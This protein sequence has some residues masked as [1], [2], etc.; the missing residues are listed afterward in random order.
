M[1]RFFGHSKAQWGSYVYWKSNAIQLLEKESI[2]IKKKGGL[3]LIGSVTDCYQPIEKKLHLTR[4]SLRIFL[5]NQIPI[6]ILTKSTLAERDFDLLTQFNYCEF[7]VSVSIL[8]SKVSRTFEPLVSTPRERIK[9]LRKANQSGLDTYTFIGPIHPFLSNTQAIFRRVSNIT[10]SIMGEIINLKCGNWKNIQSSL[11]K[12]DIFDEDYKNQANSESFYL[13]NK[14]ILN[15][16]C[17]RSSIK[18]KGI[19]KHYNPGLKGPSNI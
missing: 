6:S 3:V 18:F 11:R 17:E 14:H 19:Y 16:M 13:K 15:I 8:D 10:N 1:G 9:L 12:L 5:K 4:D 7:G 2:R